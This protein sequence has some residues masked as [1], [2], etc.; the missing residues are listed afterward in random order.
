MFIAGLGTAPILNDNTNTTILT[1]ET[2][3]VTV[4][5]SIGASFRAGPRVWAIQGATTNLIMHRNR[6]MYRVPPFHPDR[7]PFT[8]VMV[9]D[10]W[11]N[12]LQQNRRECGVLSPA[13]TAISAP[14][15][16]SAGV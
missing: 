1:N 3:T 6:V 15:A 12:L 5:G 7:S 8:T 14:P 10:T 2:G 4:G 9:T 16:P 11:Y 13:T